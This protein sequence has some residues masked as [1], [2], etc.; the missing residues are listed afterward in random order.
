MTL[1]TVLIREDFLVSPGAWLRETW[2][3]ESLLFFATAL[4]ASQLPARPEERPTRDQEVG[5]ALL[6][7]LQEVSGGSLP[8]GHTQKRSRGGGTWLLPCKS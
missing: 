7:S 4:A 5:T 3:F 1:Q 2:G 8:V 6:P